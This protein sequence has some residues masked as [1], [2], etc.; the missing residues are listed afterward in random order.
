MRVRPL[1]ATSPRPTLAGSPVLRGRQAVCLRPETERIRTARQR[2]TGLRSTAR[3]DSDTDAVDLL[4]GGFPCQDLSVAGRRAGLRRRPVRPLLRVR[5]DRRR[6]SRTADGSSL[7]TYPDYFPPT[8][9]E[10]SPSYSR[11]WPSSGFTTSPGECWTADTSECPSDG[12]ASSSLPD[13]L[14]A[15]VHPRFYLSPRAAAGI[16][17]RAEKRGKALPEALFT[18]LKTRSRANSRT[19]KAASNISPSKG[20]DH[21]T[22]VTGTPAHPDGNRAIARISRWLDRGLDVERRRMREFAA[23]TVKTN[24]R[25]AGAAAIWMSTTGTG[26]RRTTDP[27]TCRRCV[28]RCHYWTHESAEAVCGGVVRGEAKAIRILREALAEVQA[29]GRPA[30]TRLNQNTPLVGSQRLRM[31]AVKSGCQV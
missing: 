11:R 10:I 23:Q 15:D 17:R 5:T 9:A 29:M 14:E 13:V 24:A 20:A 25:N 30:S 26:I 27:R 22:Y 16:L 28:V 6:S 31:T 21:D 8:V 7:R 3:G 19:L 12:A 4:C 18:A 1:P 2:R